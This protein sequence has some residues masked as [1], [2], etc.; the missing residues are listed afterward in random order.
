M[1]AVATNPLMLTSSD[2]SNFIKVSRCGLFTSNAYAR[3]HR[4]GEERMH[5]DLACPMIKPDPYPN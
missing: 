2:V 5:D 4:C 3:E 1:P